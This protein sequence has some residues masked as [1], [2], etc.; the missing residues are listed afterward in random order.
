M[1][2]VDA[3]GA[4]VDTETVLP[5]SADLVTDVGYLATGQT[6][7]RAYGNGMTRHLTWDLQHGRIEQVA[8]VLPDTGGTTGAT[9]QA[10]MYSYDTAGRMISRPDPDGTGSQSLQWDV[11]STL[12][13]AGGETYLYDG[14]G[15]RVARIMDGAVTVWVGTDEATATTSAGSSTADVS[16]SRYY[17]FAGS[18][19]AVRHVGDV[20][21]DGVDDAGVA[22]TLGDVQGSAQV[23]IDAELSAT[24]SVETASGSAGRSTSA[25]TPYGVTRGGDNLVVSRGWLGQVED[26]STATGVTA[27]GLTYLNAR[28]YDPVLGR[29]LSPDPLMNPGDPRTLDPYRYA[30]NNPTTYT[31]ASGL[32]PEFAPG[33]YARSCDYTERGEPSV[34][35]AP[36]NP[37]TGEDIRW[38]Y[39]V[40][41]ARAVGVDIT[42]KPQVSSGDNV[43]MV[44]LKGFV[45]FLG[46][47]GNVAIDSVNSLWY[48]IPVL[49]GYSVFSGDAPPEIPDIPIWGDPDI[50]KYSSYVGSG[51]AVAVGVVDAAGTVIAGRA[52][53]AGANTAANSVRSAAPSAFTRTEA[54]SGRASQRTVNEI[55]ESMRTNG[56][57][58]APIDVVELNGERIVVDGHHRLAAARRAGIDV[59]Y[60]VVD[61]S[62]VIGPGKYTS[63]DDILQ[64]TYSVGRDRLR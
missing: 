32:G 25:Y 12:T 59:Q 63:I 53:T 56:W 24:G 42:Y 58:G 27:T 38:H 13:S 15:Q 7:S 5:T 47:A 19:V 45:N 23:T 40:A 36:G 21:R 50:Y 62:T 1:S 52:A 4:V 3:Y 48:A 46:G 8:A 30:D 14:E 49:A 51:T 9:V 61:P 6:V 35:D 16:A 34:F 33:C 39:Q 64:S 18:A 17:R 26:T 28:Y 2:G 54:L 55:A 44:A 20:D 31:D 10:D 43:G 57:Q 22:F 60:Q 11:L 37:V 29:F 41:A